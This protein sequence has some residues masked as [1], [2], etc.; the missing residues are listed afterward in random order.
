MAELLL[1]DED[2]RNRASGWP[3]DAGFDLLPVEEAQESGAA[4]HFFSKK[5]V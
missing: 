3:S 4:N 2:E 1:S 5:N